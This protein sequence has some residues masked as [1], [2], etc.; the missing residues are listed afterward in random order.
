M[1]STE[2]DQLEE[3]NREINDHIDRI[4]QRQELTAQEREEL[5]RQ[6]EAHIQSLNNRIEKE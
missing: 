4:K 1:L 5:K 2:T 6:M 3:S